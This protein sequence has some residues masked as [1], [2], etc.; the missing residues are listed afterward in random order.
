[1]LFFPGFKEQQKGLRVKREAPSKLPALSDKVTVLAGR[2]DGITPTPRRI[3]AGS[4]PGVTPTNC[5]TDDGVRL[6]QGEVEVEVKAEVQVQVQAEAEVQG[7]DWR[8]AAAAAAPNVVLV[9]AANRGITERYG[10]QPVPIRHDAAA[11]VL[12]AEAIATAGVPVDFARDAIYTCVVESSLDH[13]PRTLKY[14]VG[15]VIDRYRA[16]QTHD[17]AARS[18][19]RRLPGTNGMHR[20]DADAHFI[21]EMERLQREPANG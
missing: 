2:I 16:R 17:T 3:T 6:A 4:T 21:A 14:F 12:A 9:A 20:P 18:D 11:S 5:R 7:E 1:V 13:P 8:A 10:E 19:A 15:H